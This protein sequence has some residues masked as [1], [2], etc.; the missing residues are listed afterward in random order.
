MD[1]RDM[2][3]I[4]E[5][6]R[7]NNQLATQLESFS[8]QI[9]ANME[10]GRNNWREW[11]ASLKEN[12]EKVRRQVNEYVKTNPYQAVCGAVALGFVLGFL[13]MRKR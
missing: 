11:E 4:E 9:E 1:N 5:S 8:A 6:A 7:I 12:T 10:R 13:G 3:N 2:N